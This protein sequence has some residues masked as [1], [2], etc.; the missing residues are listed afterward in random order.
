MQRGDGKWFGFSAQILAQ[1][2]AKYLDRTQF[3]A[4]Y[5]NNPNDPGAAAISNEYF[6]H[7]DRKFLK[8]EQGKWWYNGK[9]LNVFAAVDFAFSLRKTADYSAIVVVGIDADGYIYI[10][11]INRV[12]TNKINEYFDMILSAHMKWG[13]KKLRAEVS[14]GQA[15][16]A[17]HI[18]DEIRREG[19]ALSVEDFRPTRHMGTKEERIDAALKPRYE[20][21]TI[22]HYRGGYCEDLEQ[23]LIMYNPPNDDIKDALQSVCGILRPPLGNMQRTRDRKVVTHTR[24][25]GI[26]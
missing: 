24:F 13:F 2:R 5:Y 19:L 7:Y 11:D 8:H 4:Q 15:V 18:K 25:G 21:R 17:Q 14:G 26:Q 16:I 22:W 20:N 1:K 9:I 12:K 10:L 3:Y 6:Q 23:E